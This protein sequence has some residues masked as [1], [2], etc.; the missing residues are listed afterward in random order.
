MNR[1]KTLIIA[2]AF[3]AAT[4]TIAP[5]LAQ[6][7]SSDV[8]AGLIRVGHEARLSTGGFFNARDSAVTV[9]GKVI[10]LLLFV[11][12]A[13]AVLF[14]IIGGF[15]YLTS[16]GNEEQAS[17]GRTT[18][19][20]AIIGIVIIILSYVIINAIVNLVNCRGGSIFGGC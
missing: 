13:I 14:V 15:M 10:R 18:I 7:Q 5:L 11:S 6:A 9:I 20:N 19:V 12:G 4:F 17:K 2:L 3:F 16:A 1:K 8:D